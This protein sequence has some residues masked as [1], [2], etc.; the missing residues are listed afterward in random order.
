MTEKNC[1]GEDTFLMPLIKKR[2]PADD[3]SPREQDEDDCPPTGA[4]QSAARFEDSVE[5]KWTKCTSESLFRTLGRYYDETWFPTVVN[6][7]C[8]LYYR[9]NHAADYWQYKDEW[10]DGDEEIRLAVWT[11]VLRHRDEHDASHGEQCD[12]DLL[13]VDDRVDAAKVSP[14]CDILLY[15]IIIL[16]S[17]QSHTFFVKTI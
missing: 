15:F 9:C 5:W 3:G 8:Q 11:E 14:L 17:K 10:L 13:H 6:E 4:G 7:W 12:T 2:C 1:D 16:W